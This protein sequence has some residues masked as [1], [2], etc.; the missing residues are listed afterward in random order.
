[1]MADTLLC[2]QAYRIPVVTVCHPQS[3]ERCRNMEWTLL[4]A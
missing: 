4:E 2:E 1:M 3:S